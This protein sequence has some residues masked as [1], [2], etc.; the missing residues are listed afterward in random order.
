MQRTTKQIFPEF[1]Q[2]S[3]DYYDKK[4]IIEESFTDLDQF[5]GSVL[6]SKLEYE[7][8]HHNDTEGRI[9][10]LTYLHN[11]LERGEVK[12]GRYLGGDGTAQEYTGTPDEIITQ[13]RTEWNN[14][15]E[16]VVNENPMSYEMSI[17]II[18]KDNPWPVWR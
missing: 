15:K 6:Q 12:V 4:L 16:G 3:I 1:K 2:D 11:L 13:L 10:T 9:L 7:K 18:L 8:I 5:H 17:H 14:T